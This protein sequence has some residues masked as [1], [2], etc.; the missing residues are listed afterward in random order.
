MFYPFQWTRICASKDANTS[1]ARL[2]V[3]GDVLVEQEV[4][5]KNKPD[6]LII[7]LGAWIS[8]RSGNTYEDS[9]QTTNLNVFSS[10]L[11][12]EQMKSQTTAGGEECGL[13]GDFLSWEKSVEEKQWT[14]HSKARWVD[15][16]GGLEGSCKA[17]ATM[18]VFPMNGY[19]FHSD[20]MEHCEKLGGRSPSVGKEKEWGN[21]LKGIEAV[22]PVLSK[23]PARIWLSATEG[24]IGNELGELDHWPEGV[25]AEEGVWRDYYTG[26]QLENCTKPRKFSNGDN[27]VGEAYNCI[28]FYP[29]KS[30][31]KNM[32]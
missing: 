8:H 7:V 27:E 17:K 26:E 3:D 21:L 23:L 28:H 9:G 32:G 31:Q 13:A 25:I 1:L 6:K 16:D 5:V 10:A 18:S 15:L 14:L 22:S 19:H 12:K 4:E 11:T 2:V 30:I 29:I 24:H 20:C